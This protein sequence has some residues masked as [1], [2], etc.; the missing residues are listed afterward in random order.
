M[1]RMFG[2]QCVTMDDEGKCSLGPADAPAAPG[3]AGHEVRAEIDHPAADGADEPA[4]DRGAG[5]ADGDAAEGQ[6][7]GGGAGY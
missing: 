4:L 5:A 6:A 3:A 7:R 2:G 1:L